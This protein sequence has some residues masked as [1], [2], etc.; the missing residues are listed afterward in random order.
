MIAMY[1]FKTG[2]LVRVSVYVNGAFVLSGGGYS[3][4]AEGFKECWQ[5]VVDSW[6]TFPTMGHA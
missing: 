6:L 5:F 3:S 1:A 2:G 4:I